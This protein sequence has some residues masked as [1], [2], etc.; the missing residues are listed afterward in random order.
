MIAFTKRGK[1]IFAICALDLPCI[2]YRGPVAHHRLN[3]AGLLAKPFDRFRVGNIH[4]KAATFTADGHDFVPGIQ[5]VPLRLWR[6][7]P[8]HRKG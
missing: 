4:L 3:F 6:G 5:L 7:C 2:W 8:W 1:P